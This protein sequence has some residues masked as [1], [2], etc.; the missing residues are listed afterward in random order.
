MPNT[1]ELELAQQAL[2]VAREAV[3]KQQADVR[4]LRTAAAALLTGC[5][6]VVSFLGGR[7]LDAHRF[8]VL[9]GVGVV[10][11]VV[12]LFLIVAVLIPFKTRRGRR[13][14]LKEIAHPSALFALDLD[15]AAPLAEACVRLTETYEEIYDDNEAP[16]LRI[17][18]QLAAAAMLLV[19]QV[20][21]W[22]AT[23]VLAEG[24]PAVIAA[25]A[26]C[27]SA[28][29]GGAPTCLARGQLCDPRN[30]RAYEAHM[31]ICT[32]R[33]GDGRPRLR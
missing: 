23:I 27:T 25:P 21:A 30:E 28:T 5:S 9:V 6:V 3:A 26:A 33:A 4:D 32:R 12:S 29:I 17:V 8:P 20:V 1:P 10:F 18:R 22:G 24:T 11:F 14:R 31:L 2:D 13:P 7:A 15:P 16:K 19:L